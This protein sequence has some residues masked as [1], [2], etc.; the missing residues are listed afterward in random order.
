MRQAVSVR[1][2]PGDLDRARDDS[3]DVE[4]ARLEAELPGL[5]PGEI[6]KVVDD[7]E[8]LFSRFRDGLG[9]ALLGRAEIAFGPAET[10][11]R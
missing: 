6:Q 9:V 1:L 2:R 5:E 7:D 8:E 10:T 4:R 11:C 3:A